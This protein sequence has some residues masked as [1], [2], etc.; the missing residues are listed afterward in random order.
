MLKKLILVG[1]LFYP[2]IA[3]AVCGSYWDVSAV[4]N[5]TAQYQNLSLNGKTV[6]K[7]PTVWFQNL[8]SIKQKID[9]ASGLYTKLLLCSSREVN[10]F[11]SSSSGANVVMLTFGMYD[12]I[13]NDWDAY[14]ALLGHENAH[15]VHGHGRQRKN[16][17]AVIGLL[18]AL[19]G[20][21]LDAAIEKET[22]V[23]GIGFGVANI[24][25]DAVSAGY[26]RGDELEADRSG[27]IYAYRSGFD[28]NGGLRLH[29]KM[30]KA[31]DFFSTH[32]SSQERINVLRTE[33]ARLT[34]RP[35]TDNV[36]V[37][38]SNR[39]RIISLSEPAGISTL[40]G[41]S[42]IRD[43]EIDLSGGAGSGVVV[44]VKARLG[45]FIASQTDFKPAVR[46]MKVHIITGGNKKISGTVARVVGGYFSVV[47]SSEID[48]T[49]MGKKVAFQ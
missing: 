21:V 5:R 32:P 23:K 19:A 20:A 9:A 10:A 1:L 22:G 25:S 26:S 13:G 38:T 42:T 6:K 11:A 39:R 30:S 3:F 49:I 47:P 16:R 14:A 12:L 34:T 43:S 28:P 15:L 31:S 48:N 17:Q 44:G 7:V 37:A 40:S 27:M 18:G 45:Y 46:G 8:E 33:I 2:G 36:Q 35:Q 29:H 4:T 41:N 24:T